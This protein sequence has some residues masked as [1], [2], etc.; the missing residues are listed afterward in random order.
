MFFLGLWESICNDLVVRGPIPPVLLYGA[1]EIAAA[2]RER[3]GQR[4]VNDGVSWRALYLVM[5]R[6]HS[7]RGRPFI[8]PPLI[9]TPEP[10]LGLSCVRASARYTARTNTDYFC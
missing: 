8:Q 10:L 3:R 5:R 2:Q 4:E 9:P 1:M 7:P 6:L